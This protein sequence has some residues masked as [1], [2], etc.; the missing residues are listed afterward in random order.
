MHTTF[1]LID[2]HLF[3]IVIHDIGYSLDEI[4]NDLKSEVWHYQNIGNGLFDIEYCHPGSVNSRK[5]QNIQNFLFSQEFKKQWIAQLVNN[6]IFKIQR[7]GINSDWLQKN[8]IVNIDWGRTPPKQTKAPLHN[9]DINIISFGLI[10]LIS[11][12]DVNQS[13]YFIKFNGAEEIRVPTGFGQGWIVVNTES[14]DHRAF[15][16]TNNYR[17]HLRL[18]IKPKI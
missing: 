11:H 17:Y 15:N 2:Q 12:D 7:P 13:T 9:D 1:N 5:L 6:E 4:I 14:S 10:Y 8:T 18:S 16:N 3:E